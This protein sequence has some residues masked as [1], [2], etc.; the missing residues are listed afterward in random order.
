MSETYRELEG[1]IKQ[2][3]S[4]IKQM[5][6]LANSLNRL[7]DGLGK[8]FNDEEVEECDEL[9]DTRLDNENDVQKIIQAL[10]QWSW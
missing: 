9:Y 5:V 10:E 6:Q 2:G 4:I 3:K 7:Y 8:G 1:E